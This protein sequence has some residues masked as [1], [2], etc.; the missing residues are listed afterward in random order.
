MLNGSTIYSSLDCIS[1]YYYIT[2]SPEDQKKAAFVIPVA[3]FKS[4]KVHFSLA[5]APTHFQ[6]L[7]NKV[8]KCLPFAFGYLYDIIIFIESVEKHFS[9]L[10]TVFNRL[11]LEDLK[12]K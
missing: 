7:I 12:L 1:G 10:G 9:H 5:Q 3:K 11:R 4:M 8:L 6:Q 2:L